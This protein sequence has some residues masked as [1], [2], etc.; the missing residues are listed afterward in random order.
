MKEERRRTKEISEVKSEIER[1]EEGE[2]EGK[3]RWRK[4]SQ[5]RRGTRELKEEAGTRG[6][7]RGTREIQE[8]VAMALAMRGGGMSKEEKKERRMSREV[9]GR[10]EAGETVLKVERRGTREIGKESRRGTREMNEEELTRRKGGDL[11]KV[12]QCCGCRDKLVEERRRRRELLSIVVQR[13]HWEEERRNK[14]GIILFLFLVNIIYV[15]ILPLT[16]LINIF[17]T[18][19]RKDQHL[20]FPDHH[21]HP[22]PPSH[23]NHHDH[24]DHIGHGKKEL[25]KKD[26][27]SFISQSYSTFWP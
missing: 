3:S 27:S 5:E 1:G 19:R 25:V 17:N 26:Q 6:E 8:E 22:G 23:H 15:D 21:C 18:T 4:K 2:E 12:E 13:L 16:I 14:V 20:V 9:V 7:R 11:V 10:G 24:H